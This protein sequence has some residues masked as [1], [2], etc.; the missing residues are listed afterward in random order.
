MRLI[1]ELQGNYSLIGT[2]MAGF[3][4]MGDGTGVNYYQ[5]KLQKTQIILCN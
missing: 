3:V 4:P 1:K 5:Q 2:F